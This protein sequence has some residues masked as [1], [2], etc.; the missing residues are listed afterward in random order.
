[1]Y[2]ENVWSL[3]EA[4]KQCWQGDS[5]NQ[6]ISTHYLKVYWTDQVST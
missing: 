4:R 1:M 6:Y 5:G 2:A 3:S